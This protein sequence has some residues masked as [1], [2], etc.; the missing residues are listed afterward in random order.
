MRIEICVFVNVRLASTV[1]VNKCIIATG[2]G[3]MIGSMLKILFF[4]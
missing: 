4:Y 3:H 2:T 1:S